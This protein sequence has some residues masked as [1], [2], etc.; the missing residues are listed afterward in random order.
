MSA[1]GESGEKG[2]TWMGDL[3]FAERKAH[4]PKINR[5]PKLT[6]ARILFHLLFHCLYN[7]SNMHDGY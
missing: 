4:V 2:D 5:E 6:S 7:L 1:E 3:W